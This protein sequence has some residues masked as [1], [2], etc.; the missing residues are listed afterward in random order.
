MTCSYAYLISSYLPASVAKKG[1]RI[2]QNGPLIP[3]GASTPSVPGLHKPAIA[4]THSCLL[5]TQAPDAAAATMETRPKQD[6]NHF[7]LAPNF[8]FVSF[9]NL[10][11]SGKQIKIRSSASPKGVNASSMLLETW[12]IPLTST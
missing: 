5:M 7:G 12:E 9:S 10:S 6:F 2:I 11:I 1:H 8:F 3:K 4:D